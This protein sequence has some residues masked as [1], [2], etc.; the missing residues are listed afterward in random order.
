MESWC[1]WECEVISWPL[2]RWNT[3]TVLPFPTHC[4][5]LLSPKA[6]AYEVFRLVMTAWQPTSCSHYKPREPSCRFVSSL[7]PYLWSK[8]VLLVGPETDLGR[9][10][11]LQK[12]SK[13]SSWVMKPCSIQDT[14]AARAAQRWACDFEVHRYS[15]GRKDCVSILGNIRWKRRLS[16]LSREELSLRWKTAAWLWWKVQPK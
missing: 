7:L 4:V 11:A 15:V 10:V 9:A 6:S 5:F 3:C 2:L 16:G 14:R 13:I 8:A 12:Q 1:C